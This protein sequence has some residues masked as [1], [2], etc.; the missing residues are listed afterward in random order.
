MFFSTFLV[1][2]KMIIVVGVNDSR[3]VCVCVCNHVVVED[4]SSGRD[5]CKECKRCAAL[6]KR[7]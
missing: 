4:V 2:K 3:E 7:C 5:Q 6:C 1:N